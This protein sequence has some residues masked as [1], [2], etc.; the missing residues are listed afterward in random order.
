MECPQI[1]LED[2]EEE[3]QRALGDHDRLDDGS[4]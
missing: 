2:F 1:S 3:N 4:D